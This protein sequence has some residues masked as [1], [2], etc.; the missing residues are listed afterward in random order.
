M[1]NFIYFYNTCGRYLLYIPENA[2]LASPEGIPEEM[3]LRQRIINEAHDIV[4]AEHCGVRKTFDRIAANLYWPKLHAH[5]VDYV[6]GCH[7][8][9]R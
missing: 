3:K 7:K 8:C 4:I 2:V 1:N 9:H 5:C 6:N